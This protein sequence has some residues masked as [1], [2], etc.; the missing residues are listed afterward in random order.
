MAIFKTEE[1]VKYDQ[2][3][4]GGAISTFTVNVT[5]E[6]G[7]DLKR[8]TL[9]TKSGGA[10]KATQT[11]VTASAILVDD[12]KAEADTVA[13]IYI[14]G[15]FNREAII[16]SEGDTVEAHEEELRSVGIYLTGMK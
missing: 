5:I 7:Q 9:M 6:A 3:I 15:L 11:G 13:P 12:V 4:G 10:Y 8:G 16:V 2:L 1:G 14:R